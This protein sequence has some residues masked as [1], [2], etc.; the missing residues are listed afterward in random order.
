MIEAVSK[1]EEALEK[2]LKEEGLEELWQLARVHRYWPLIVERPLSDRAR[3][4]KIERGVLTLLVADSAYAQHLKFY[5][6]R[7][8]DQLNALDSTLKLSALKFQVG[9]MARGSEAD[10]TQQLP[11]LK[12]LAERVLSGPKA[13]LFE[14]IYELFVARPEE[15]EELILP[16]GTQIRRLKRDQLEKPILPIDP[17]AA[18]QAQEQ[19]QKINQPKVAQAFSRLMANRLSAQKKP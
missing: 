2:A 9:E 8:L 1:L 6:T 4:Y 18:S 16:D 7:F 3:P 12:A 14:R 10:L 13:H 5:S 11:Q 15:V 19:A 17:L